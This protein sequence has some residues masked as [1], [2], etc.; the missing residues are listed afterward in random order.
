MLHQKTPDTNGWYWLE[1]DG[2]WFMG[3]MRAEEDVPQLVL[4]IEENA[5][6]EQFF[7]QSPGRFFNQESGTFMK[8]TAWIG[9]LECPGQPF[10]HEIVE[11]SMEQHERAIREGK[12]LVM[13]VI[14]SQHCDGHMSEIIEAGYMDADKALTTVGRMWNH[15]MEPIA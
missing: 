12:S 9:P 1:D 8:P 3:Y 6:M 14:N 15:G 13:S 5:T 2:E 4:A 10:H 7:E 11:F